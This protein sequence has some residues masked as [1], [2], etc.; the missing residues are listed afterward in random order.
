VSFSCSDN[1]NRPIANMA[2]NV[3][4]ARMF[5]SALLII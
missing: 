4:R 5:R 2:A 3:A 1:D